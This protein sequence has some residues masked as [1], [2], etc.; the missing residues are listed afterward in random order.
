MVD[1]VYSV[2]VRTPIGVKRGAI[3]LAS[4]GGELSG[5]MEAFGSRNEFSGGAV[6]GDAIAF[7]GSLKTPAGIVGFSFAG[8]ADGQPLEGVAKTA[9][10]DLS[11]QGA[12]AER[13][14]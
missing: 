5:V 6:E 9:K 1:G 2:K 14:A 10:G 11:I 3:Q 12:R 13:S 8:T 7:G 4:N